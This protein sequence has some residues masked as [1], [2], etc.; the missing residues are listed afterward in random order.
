MMND[1]TLK[2]IAEVNATAS[3][4]SHIWIWSH[5]WRSSDR[6]LFE[7]CAYPPMASV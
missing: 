6:P 5:I 2:Q 4:G 3:K 1:V 7:I